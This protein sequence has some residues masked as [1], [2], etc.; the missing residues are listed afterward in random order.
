[1]S[2]QVALYTA[3]ARSSLPTWTVE[4][5]PRSSYS[6]KA[7][8]SPAE[9]KKTLYRN[10]VDKYRDLQARVEEV[11]RSECP[12]TQ[13]VL[14]QMTRELAVLTPL[15]FEAVLY[16]TCPSQPDDP[17]LDERSLNEMVDL[18]IEH[19]PPHKTYSCL[20]DMILSACSVPRTVPENG[21]TELP[22]RPYLST[23]TATNLLG[24]LIQ[25]LRNDPDYDMAQASRWIRCVVQVAL[26]QR[27]PSSTV[28][29]TDDDRGLKTVEMATGQAQALA[30]SA[31]TTI[32]GSHQT[33]HQQPY[34]PE[35][36]EWLATT[37]FNLAIDLYMVS[38][39]GNLPKNLTSDEANPS[40]DLT[41]PQFWASKATE[42]ADV[43]A[44]GVT[45]TGSSSGQTRGAVAVAGTGD[46]DHGSNGDGGLL[47]G[48]L[49]ERCQSL[50]WHV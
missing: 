40:T 34:P 27:A 32:S 1:M 50:G 31:A 2:V 38:C 16:V 20:A 49:R 15:A 44:G 39:T 24:K 14:E 42:I 3:Q 41:T 9:I 6:S 37:L 10:A 11:R 30:R 21:H 8:P 7:P 45:R 35:E 25:G 46:G 12:S 4:D 19:R 17:P 26:D 13:A 23:S 5:I 18:A 33:C 22:T 36:L 29:R 43:L 48:I 28:P 47:A